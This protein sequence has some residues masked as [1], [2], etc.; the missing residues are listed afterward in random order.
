MAKIVIEVDIENPD[1]EET[2]TAI[3]EELKLI[4]IVLTEFMESRNFD[5]ELIER[6]GFWPQ[7]FTIKVVK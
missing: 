7:D 3:K 5:D 1:T 6:Y 2:H 4:A